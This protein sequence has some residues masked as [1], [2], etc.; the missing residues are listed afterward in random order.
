MELSKPKKLHGSQISDSYTGGSGKPLGQG[1]FGTVFKATSKETGEI[2]AIKEII[3]S[4]NEEDE[5]DDEN[6][7]REISILENYGRNQNQHV[8]VFFDSLFATVDHVRKL[9]LVFE[10]LDCNLNEY[11]YKNDVQSQKECYDWMLQLLDG[12]VFLQSNNIVH[13]DLK[14]DNILV[15]VKNK[16]LKIADFGLSRSNFKG[17]REYTVLIQTPNYRAP[18]IFLEN[19]EYNISVDMWSVGVIFLELGLKGKRFFKGDVN[20]IV[21]K[22]FLLFGIPR[23]DKKYPYYDRSYFQE[24]LKDQPKL[25][26]PDNLNKDEVYLIKCM[27]HYNIKK[28]ISASR[29]LKK[30]QFMKAKEKF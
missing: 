28:R 27:M 4:Q 13:R 19:A 9:Y 23:R 25:T 18:E 22:I 21:T 20:A 10:C 24:K 16:I 17:D 29:A 5:L 14:P 11:L 30:L 15:D 1:V 26:L 2:V 6:A 7:I 3:I 8:V 12:M